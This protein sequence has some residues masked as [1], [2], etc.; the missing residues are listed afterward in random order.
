MGTVCVKLP[1]V[2]E[3][4]LR[5]IAERRKTTK[6]TILRAALSEYPEDS[7]GE[8]GPSCHDLAKHLSGCLSG[9]PRDLSWNK[10]HLQGYGK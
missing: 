9:G 7:L 3:M 10:K 8:I 2:L 6:A 4:K 5:R 1:E